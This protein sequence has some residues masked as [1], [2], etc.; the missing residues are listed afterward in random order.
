MIGDITD[1]PQIEKIKAAQNH[2]HCERFIILLDIIAIESI[3]RIV[4]KQ[5]ENTR[6]AD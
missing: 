6:Y 3:E 5:H 1:D 2:R 4:Q